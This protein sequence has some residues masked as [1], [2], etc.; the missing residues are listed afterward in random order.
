[1]AQFTVY[2]IAYICNSCNYVAIKTL[3]LLCQY[4]AIAMPVCCNYYAIT[5]QL[6]CNYIGN[7]V[8][9]NH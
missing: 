6:L 9:K 5:L 7:D 2:E 3:Q 1:M 8:L 4:I